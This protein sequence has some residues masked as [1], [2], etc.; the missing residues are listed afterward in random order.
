M[1]LVSEVRSAS[2]LRMRLRGQ[3]RELPAAMAA[4]EAAPPARRPTLHGAQPR[5]SLA[6]RRARGRPSVGGSRR[7]FSKDKPSRDKPSKHQASSAPPSSRSS[8]DRPREK[9]IRTRDPAGARRPGIPRRTPRKDVPAQSSNRGPSHD[10]DL[11]GK[12][13]ALARQ[14]NRAEEL[15]QVLLNQGNHSVY[16]AYAD[17]FHQMQAGTPKVA[18]AAS[19]PKLDELCG[20]PPSPSVAGRGAPRALAPAAI[21]SR[22]AQAV[23]SPTASTPSRGSASASVAAH[24]ERISPKAVGNTG[25]SALSRVGASVISRSAPALLP[26]V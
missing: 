6:G 1:R 22:R 4:K 8:A 24:L 5:D 11:Q 23:L 21:I 14:V 17:I 12:L 2:T 18:R 10:K 15:K 13:P 19:T 16:N 25:Q 7:A 26:P 9:G 20:L 3:P